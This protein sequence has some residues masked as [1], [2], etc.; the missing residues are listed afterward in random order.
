MRLWFRNRPVLV[1]SETGEA[2]MVN[3]QPR[4]PN[5]DEILALLK[6]GKKKQLFSVEHEGRACHYVNGRDFLKRTFVRAFNQPVQLRI[7][8]GTVVGCARPKFIGHDLAHSEVKPVD[9][10][11]YKQAKLDIPTAV[12]QTHDGPKSM[13]IPAPD[14]CP[15]CAHYSK[16]LGCREDEHHFVCMYHDRW[17]EIRAARLRAAPPPPT[18]APIADDE[19]T[20]PSTVYVISLENGEPLREATAEECSLA[21]KLVEDGQL[22]LIAIDGT[23]YAIGTEQFVLPS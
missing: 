6:A 5:K 22:P 14:K 12:I 8:T 17:E 7:R 4:N 1:D 9:G 20:S 18:P 2:V 3:G 10:R 15:K 13:P 23:E 11:S 19:K 16:P 21:Q